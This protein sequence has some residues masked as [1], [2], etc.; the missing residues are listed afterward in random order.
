MDSRQRNVLALAILA[1]FIPFAGESMINTLLPVI[2]R[3]LGGG[4]AVQQWVAN[5]YLLTLGSCILIAGSLSDLFGRMRVLRYGLVGFGLS[6]LLCTF[7]PNDVV[8]VIARLLQGAAGA[9]ILP[10]SLALI[11]D[12]ISGKHFS[13]AIGSR[14]AWT[15]IA[16][17]VG[18]LLGGFFVD[19]SSW[20]L[21]FA[22]ALVP[23]GAALWLMQR[24]PLDVLAK[25]R[26][27]IDIKGS[28]LCFAA[29]GG[30]VFGF[31][32]QA[33]L[34]WASIA[35]P[36]LVGGVI[37][38]GAFLWYESR[39][40]HP[41]L[42]L[43]LFNR[44][45][46]TAGNI[47]TFTIYG[48]L[49]AWGFVVVLFLQQV[50]GYSA[51]ASGLSTI[52]V[53]IIMFLGSSHVGVLS[54]R[55][56]PRRFMAAGSFVAAAGIALLATQMKEGSNYVSDILPGMLIFGLGV[57]LTATP[58]T[59]AVL[60]AVSKA[61]SGIASAVNNAVVSIAGLLTIAVIGIVLTTQFSSGIDRGIEGAGMSVEGRQ[62]LEEMKQRSPQTGVPISVPPNETSVARAVLQGASTDSFRTSMLFIA[63]LVGLGGLVAIIGVK[64][65]RLHELTEQTAYTRQS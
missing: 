47:A 30:I 64:D 12:F 23:V 2:E 34:G 24:L 50:A 21:A 10:A 55:F 36:C 19:N 49:T 58:L 26:A 41:M 52:P 11:S 45:N 7:A 3:E 28:L 43:Q 14:T 60:S 61:R 33:R 39:H 22:T 6:S 27:H 46:F 13:K 20:R 56:G 62:A 53:T 31:I 35:L 57:T 65:Q 48:G 32:E 18:P 15:S 29:L 17:V 25:R 63:V 54:Q 5:G 16:F 59:A 40:S 51:L 38:F 9:L 4:L 42:P 37:L 8:L 1:S 44:R